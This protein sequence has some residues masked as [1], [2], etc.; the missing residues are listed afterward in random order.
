MKQEYISGNKKNPTGKPSD[1]LL[2]SNQNLYNL[3]DIQIVEILL[4]VA[5]LHNG[6]VH[7]ALFQNGSTIELAADEKGKPF[8]VFSSE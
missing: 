6:L 4:G 1:F 2:F 8:S 3:A 5:V 7:K